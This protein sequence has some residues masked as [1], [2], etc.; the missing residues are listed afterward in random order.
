MRSSRTVQ[1]LMNA[2]NSLLERVAILERKV[3]GSLFERVA[4]LERKV[5]EHDASSVHR[6]VAEDARIY[7]LELY[8]DDHESWHG[9]TQ[10]IARIV[11]LEAAI[12]A[13]KKGE[14]NG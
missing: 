14:H 9:R 4:I 3:G 12:E 13:L 7:K 11:A 5:S 8:K 1:Y 2:V 6:M 10:V